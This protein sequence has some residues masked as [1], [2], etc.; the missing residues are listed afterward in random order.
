MNDNT[1]ELRKITAMT[2]QGKFDVYLSNTDGLP[3]YCRSLEEIVSTVGDSLENPN[4]EN[5]PSLHLVELYMLA[6]HWLL[7][8]TKVCPS[9][10]PLFSTNRLGSDTS[11]SYVLLF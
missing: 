4:V 7:V 10:S 9:G 5:I 6:V 8:F 11:N 1:R 3:K 2:Q